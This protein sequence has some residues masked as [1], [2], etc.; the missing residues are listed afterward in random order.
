MAQTP[1]PIPTDVAMAICTF[2]KS[3][4]DRFTVASLFR[5]PRIQAASLIAFACSFPVEMLDLL[6]HHLPRQQVQTLLKEAHAIDYADSVDML[7]WWKTS[8]LELADMYTEEAIVSASRRRRVDLLQ[9]WRGSGLPLKYDADAIESACGN[10]CVDVLRWW[11]DSGLEMKYGERAIA[12]ASLYGHVPVLQWWKDS[13]LPLEYDN[14]AIAC[15]SQ[16]GCVDVL[17]WW[18]ESG[19]KVKYNVAAM[20]QASRSGRTEVLQWWLDS[21]YELRYRNESVHGAIR[22]GRIESLQWWKESGLEIEWAA[23]PFKDVEDVKVLQWWA[24]SG[25]FEQWLELQADVGEAFKNEGE[26]RASLAHPEEE[27]KAEG[28]LAIALPNSAGDVGLFCP[29]TIRPSTTTCTPHSGASKS[30]GLT[31]AMG[32]DCVIAFWATSSSSKKLLRVLFAAEG[33]EGHWIHQRRSTFGRGDGD[34]K[35]GSEKDVEGMGA[36]VQAGQIG[37]GGGGGIFAFAL[38]NP[39]F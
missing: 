19:L 18:K 17:Q 30:S 11:K 24:A 5:L 16:A 8:G 9:W 15:A 13:G 12:A 32:S 4:R 14:D 20:D 31:P 6:Q 26:V 2:S 7:Q 37:G 27:G 29:I 28:T 35:A 25:L 36:V 23:L 39:N 3:P 1:R 38:L 34:V 21:G 10:G 22:W 33:V